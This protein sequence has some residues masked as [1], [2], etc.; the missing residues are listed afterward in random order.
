M[1]ET[2]ELTQGQL[3]GFLRRGLFLALSLAVLI[4]A[5]MYYW[6]I[7]SGPAFRAE[8]VLVTQSP[9]VD[10]KTLGLPEVN[11]SPLHVDAYSVAANSTPVL[12]AALASIGPPPTEAELD[13]LRRDQLQIRVVPEPKLLYLTVT[14]DDPVRAA[15]L[16]NAIADQ[17]QV[18]DLSRITDE[19]TRVASILTQRIIK[20]QVLIEQLASQNTDNNGDQL[21][22]ER[23]VLTGL[24]SQ[25]DSVVSLS[26]NASSTLTVLRAATPPEEGIGR[27]PGMFALLGII[28][29]VLIAYALIFVIGLVDGRFYTAEGIEHATNLP[30]LATL[31]HRRRGGVTPV[32]TAVTLH[33]NIG[34][35]V[36][37]AEQATLLVTG[38]TYRGDTALTAMAVA[39][40]FA[41]RGAK[42]LLVDADLRRP[43]IGQQYRVPGISKLSLI[44]CTRG[45]QALQQPS[46]VTVG[47]HSQ[48]SLIYETL[49]APEETPA[50]LDGLAVCLERWKEEY[51]AI[52]V[53]TAPVA[54][55]S[56]SLVIGRSC[57][58]AILAVDPR[59]AHR[60]QL[61][62]VIKQLGRA[63]VSLIGIVATGPQRSTKA[64]GRLTNMASPRVL[65]TTRRDQ[66]KPPRTY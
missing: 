59:R 53:R 14:A 43:A 6:S 17:L 42:T 15:A 10:L 44:T 34:T 40:S 1:N 58:G 50:M 33:A 60:H 23:Q 13:A 7:R 27:P 22:T 56:D 66:A 41:R 63:G 8:A 54:V 49:P 29:G 25:L 28:L 55:G 62:N 16:A 61:L 2:I 18:W 47:D 19:L 35:V 4:G 52:I 11:N 46:Q 45:Q 51:D 24:D 65:S 64:R 39:E 37:V 20:Q 31:P 48:L 9:Q 3:L 26:S 12:T 36:D 30:I 57:R 5:G 38:P 21:I 32:Q